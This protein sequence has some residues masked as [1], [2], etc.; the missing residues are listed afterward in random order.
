M[1]LAGRGFGKTRTGA[2]FVRAEVEAGRAGR[3]A[4]V[5]PTAADARDV[6]VE[7][8]S[9]LL[10]ICPPSNRPRYEP[11]K[12]RVTWDNGA[13]AT[14]YSADEPER[15]RGPQHD[16]AW[17]DELAAWR[18]PET[19][20]MLMFGLRLG[21][22]PRVVVTTTPRPTRLIRDLLAAPTTV[23]T[24][25][26]TYDNR[27]NL[28][29]AFLEQIVRKYE[30]T[31]LGRQELYAEVLDDVPG[32]LWTRAMIEAAEHSGPIPELVR[33][34]VAIDPAVTSGDDSDET[35][36]IVAGIGTDDF[37]YVLA[38]RTCRM[39]PDGWATRAVVALDEFSADRIVAEVNNGG[40][41]VEA[42]IRTVRRHA[43][44]RKVHATRG[45][46]VRA[47]PIAAL[48]EQCV[49]EGTK[50]RV[51][52][53]EARIE[54]V[55][56][57]DLVWTRKGLRP[58][59]WAGQTGVRQ[60]MTI[61]TATSVLRCTADHP[62]YVEGRGFVRADTLVP[63][64]DMLAAWTNPANVLTA[65]PALHL[66][67]VHG[68]DHAPRRTDGEPAAS[69][70][71]STKPSAGHATISNATDTYGPEGTVE[72]NCF[73]APSGKT[74][75]AQSPT[76]GTFTTRTATRPTTTWRTLS[77]CLAALTALF[78][79]RT[80]SPSPT[81]TREPAA[82]AAPPSSPSGRNQASAPTSAGEIG[83][84]R[85]S[86]GGEPVYN[87]HVEGEPEFFANGLLVHNCRVRHVPGLTALE[88][89]MVTF[90]PE[91]SDGSPDRVDA[92][93]WALTDLDEPNFD[94]P[95]P[96][97]WN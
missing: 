17:P 36:I 7:G 69:H 71:A 67:V 21:A 10:A 76:V 87:L 68:V 37:V 94:L 64:R 39:S 2:E 15:L 84:Q 46:R 1:L 40:D 53:G 8:E 19:W 92:L 25:G 61:Q 34:V 3:V 58:V 82:N 35:G 66:S 49:A 54:D 59:L 48:Y 81:D 77:R 60:T 43:P 12:R 31:R 88:D 89:Q 50:V 13:I 14:L 85:L 97:G 4:L 9:G 72:T 29:P 79:D 74:P 18:Y 70:F 27:A 20:D 51:A 38:D 75:T 44:Y 73:T 93:V 83:M 42:T 86:E 80:A 78:T 22:R 16:L 11:S 45:K 33:V 6:M 95:P 5:A 90:L 47:E 57:G 56:A 96:V 41:L 28:A 91:G 32:A 55:R 26:S 30:G 52:A 65:E 63:R 23:V 24:R 62:V